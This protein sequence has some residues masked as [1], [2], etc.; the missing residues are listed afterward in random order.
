M[1]NLVVLLLITLTITAYAQ[2]RPID[3]EITEALVREGISE[4]EFA[5]G[6]GTAPK[7]LPDAKK[8]AQV[9]AIADVFLQ[10]ADNVRA[11]IHASKDEPFHEDVAEHYSTVAQMPVVPVPL[12]RIVR[13]R[14]SPDRSSDDTNTYAVVACNRQKIIDLYTQKAKKL[15]TEIN[16]ILAEGLRG[17]TE[18]VAEQYLGTYRRYE[19]LKEAELII[20]GTEY[21]PNP[22][23]AFEKLL[24]YLE[25]EGSQEE[26]I[27]FLDSYFQ[28]ASPLVIKDCDSVAKAITMQLEMQGAASP[29]TKVQLDAFTY[30][31]T[32]VPTGFAPILVN[33]LEKQMIGKWKPILKTA[34]G[35]KVNRFGLGANADSRLTGTYWERGNKVTIRTTLRDASTG[36]FQAVAIVRFNKYAPT[37]IRA[38]KYKPYNYEEIVRDQMIAAQGKLGK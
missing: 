21:K 4:R 27:D 23:V 18:S 22:K 31:A 24:N 36:D 35:S 28:N 34:L 25:T 30:G 38:D 6:I 32:G 19:T 1:R 29:Y 16:Q 9:D 15:R 3:R 37:D 17:D 2:I 33:R 12:P 7:H 10:V 26:T 20:V 14:L 5:I 11:I 13:V 8:L